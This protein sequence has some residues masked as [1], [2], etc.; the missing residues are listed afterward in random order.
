MFSAVFQ[1]FSLIAGTIGANIAQT[2]DG[3]DMQK[4]EQCAKRA[5]LKSKILSLPDKYE[6]LLNR[7]V[8]ENAVMLS[9]ERHSV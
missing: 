9:G 7:E 3:I 4:V 1:Q 6:T 5:G 2:E 8:Y